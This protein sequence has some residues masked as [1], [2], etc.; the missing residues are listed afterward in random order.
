MVKPS[1]QLMTKVV[2]AGV[3]A[4]DMRYERAVAVPVVKKR[5]FRLHLQ[6]WNQ[7]YPL[8]VELR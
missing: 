6:R 1:Q 8:E 3:C 7:R 5:L 4:S 2:V